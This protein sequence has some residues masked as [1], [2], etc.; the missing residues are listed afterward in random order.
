MTKMK[1]KAT[2]T[3]TVKL[4]EDC[5]TEHDEIKE[6]CYL[7]LEKDLRKALKKNGFGRPTVYIE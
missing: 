1:M 5:F 7:A 6:K 3:F 4:S 2:V